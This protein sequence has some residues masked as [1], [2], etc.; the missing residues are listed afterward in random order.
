MNHYEPAY[1]LTLRLDTSAQDF[2]DELRQRYFPPERNFLKAH[3]TLFHK[4]PITEHTVTLL[5]N[6]SFLPFDIAI[7]GLMNLGNGVAF[8]LEG[9]ELN[10]LHRNLKHLFSPYL[11]PQ[12]AQGFRAHVTI[13]NKVTPIEARSLLA[14][15]SADFQPFDA[16]ALGLDLWEYLGGPWDHKHFFPFLT[17]KE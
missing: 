6:L 17:A 15:L 1:I 7:S 14:E 4:L 13:Q 16:I 12:D 9:K 10:N 8:R 5:Q 11:T 3:L 2:F